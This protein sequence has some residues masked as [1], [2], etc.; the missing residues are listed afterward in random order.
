MPGWQTPTTNAKIYDDLPQ[1]ACDYVEYIEKFVGTPIKY[2]GTGPEREAAIQPASL[3]I[4][5]KHRSP[6]SEGCEAVSK[7]F[8]DS[9][10]IVGP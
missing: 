1:R 2:I 9:K 7:P 10:L 6:F 5:M 4:R 8:R 3:R